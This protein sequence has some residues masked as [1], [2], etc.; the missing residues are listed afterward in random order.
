[1]KSTIRTSM[2]GLLALSAL[3]GAAQ[4]SEAGSTIRVA[5][6]RYIGEDGR[7][8]REDQFERPRYGDHWGSHRY[9]GRP[10]PEWRHA[11]PVFGRP[12]WGRF[13]DCRVIVKR[14]IKPWGERVVRRV[15]VCD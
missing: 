12:G 2:I 6:Y 8:S 10:V 15:Q 13:D 11:R 3:G 14:H 4:A 7:F 5:D 9:W 1:M